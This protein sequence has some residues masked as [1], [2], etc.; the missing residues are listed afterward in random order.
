MIEHVPV[1]HQENFRKV[2]E[3]NRVILGVMSSGQ[4]VDVK[5]LAKLCEEQQTLILKGFPGHKIYFPP[6]VHELFA[7]L[8]M[9]IGNLFKK[10]F[11]QI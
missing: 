9:M 3:N 2:M 8:P 4:K 5:K 6:T 1:Q 7:H 11:S 10:D